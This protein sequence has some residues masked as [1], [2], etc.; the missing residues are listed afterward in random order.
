[1]RRL[2]VVT[3]RMLQTNATV[4][5]GDDGILVVDSPYFPDELDALA[6]MAGDRA[7]VRL[8]AT[9]SHYDHLMGRLAFPDAPLHV[10]RAT[11]ARLADDPDEPARDLADED[12][13]TY[14]RRDRPLLLAPLALAEELTGV[15][16]LDTPGHAPDG[17]AIVAGDTVCCG[18]YLSDVEIPLLSAAG[19]LPDYVATLERLRA[20]VARAGL[21]VP[22]HGGPCGP[23]EALARLE[24]DLAYLRELP[25]G[26][27]DQRLP[28]GRDTPRQREIHRSNLER[29]V[30][31]M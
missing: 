9:H 2:G 24:A 4:L 5:E 1:M 12:A 18:D 15:E 10:A 7:P 13:R 8:A 29:H 23:D 11:A 25:A 22:G 6:A 26:D 16:I 17:I 31:G 30:T 19:S 14:V 20:P 28:A 27:P 21:V 3:S